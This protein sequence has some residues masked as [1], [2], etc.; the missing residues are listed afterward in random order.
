MEKTKKIMNQINRKNQPC[1]FSN[2]LKKNKN[3]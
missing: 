2:K 3:K 1:I